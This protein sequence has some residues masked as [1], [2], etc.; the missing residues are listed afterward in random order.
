MTHARFAETSLPSAKVLA[1]RFIPGEGVA[2]DVARIAAANVLMV[3]CAQVVIPLPWTPVPITGQTFGVL[4]IGALLGARRGAVV[5]G[6][7]LLEG[8]SGLPVFQPLGKPGILRLTDP[9]AGFLLSYPL[10]TFATGYIVERARGLASAAWSL[11]VVG[12][13]LAGE[14][15]IFGM[16]AFWLAS[17]FG[18]GWATAMA[19]GVLPFLAVEVVKMCLVALTLG[20]AEKALE[21]GSAAGG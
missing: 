4:L 6:L 9:T 12:G 19:V 10:A 16:G 14:M 11:C 13:M 1:D 20:G 17:I 15:V 3:L 7:Y 5:L 2:W 21:Q 18:M 8:F